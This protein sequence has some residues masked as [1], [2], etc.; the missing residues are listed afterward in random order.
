MHSTSYNLLCGGSRAQSLYG[1]PPFSTRGNAF[2][3]ASPGCP[4]TLPSLVPRPK[5]S[6]SI[7]VIV[8]ATD[9]ISVDFIVD[10][11]SPQRERQSTIQGQEIDNVC[12]VF[13]ALKIKPIVSLHHAMED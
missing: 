2:S 7:R 9:Q 12:C 11:L 6:R 10:I 4:K 1:F 13:A 8:A 5:D 3:S